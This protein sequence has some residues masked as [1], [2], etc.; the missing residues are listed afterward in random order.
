VIQ[1]VVPK[2]DVTKKTGSYY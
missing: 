1:K 2:Q